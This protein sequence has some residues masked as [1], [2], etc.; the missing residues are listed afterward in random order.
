MGSVVEAERYVSV[1][2]GPVGLGQGLTTTSSSPPPSSDLRVRALSTTAMGPGHTQRPVASTETA[3][4][5]SVQCPGPSSRPPEDL[6]QDTRQRELSVLCQETPVG[7]A[8]EAQGLHGRPPG[9]RLD[10]IRNLASSDSK[11]RTFIW[12]ERS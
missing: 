7:L 11:S 9:L 5:C 12:Q 4:Y 8:F 6:S 1:A 3:G 2:A 10:G